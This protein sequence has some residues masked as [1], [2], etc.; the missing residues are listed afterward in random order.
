MEKLGEFSE[1]LLAQVAGQ[2]GRDALVV[3]ADDERGTRGEVLGRNGFSGRC[4]SP[5]KAVS[6]ARRAAACYCCWRDAGDS[7]RRPLP[8]G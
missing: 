3:L 2:R 7:L 1:K 6:S 5:P 4:Q 8:A